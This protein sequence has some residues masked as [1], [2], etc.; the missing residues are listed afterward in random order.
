MSCPRPKITKQYS[1]HV[2]YYSALSY[3][4]YNQ[5]DPSTRTHASPSGRELKIAAEHAVMMR[6][7]NRGLYILVAL[8]LA[9]IALPIAI[10]Y[11]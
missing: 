10:L 5:R 3:I 6:M 9:L 2:N 7:N 4:T 8:A 1:R 11:T